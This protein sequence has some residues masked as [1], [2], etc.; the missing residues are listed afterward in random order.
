MNKKYLTAA[1]CFLTAFALWTAAVA[2]VD[3]QPIGPE[4][5][6]VGFAALNRFIHNLTGVH[7]TL[8][9]LTDWLSLI[10][11]LLAAGFAC[12]GLSQWIRRKS[13]WS[14][15]HSILV[16]GC[17]YLVTGVV[18][19]F[20]EKFIINYRP[21]LIEGIL[22][23]SYPSSTTVLVI[24][25]MSTAVPE[26]RK[27]IPQPGLGKLSGILMGLFTAFTVIGR[28]FS[29]VHWFTD[30]LGGIFLSYGLV[31]LYAAFAE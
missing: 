13:L 23:A 26:L 1:V 31:M 7:M 19:V 4:N 30:I 8:Y 20:F 3:L 12:L 24:C 22:E 14:V 10:P 25:I 6:T 11:I 2:T 5:S 15:D 17:F 21:V 29:G 27:R 28:L 18:Y 9:N 16:L